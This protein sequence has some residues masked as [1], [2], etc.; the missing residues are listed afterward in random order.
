MLR[1]RQFVRR[2][3][4]LCAVL[5]LTAF[6]P[7]SFAAT[8]SWCL[9]GGEESHVTSAV[10]PCDTPQVDAA[11]GHAHCHGVVLHT[12]HLSAA[13]DLAAAPASALPLTLADVFWYPVFTLVA[14]LAPLQPPATAGWRPGSALHELRPRLAGAV[15]GESIRLLI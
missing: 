7:Q 11:A 8:L 15:A 1:F 6:V 4:G 3:P 13:S 2:W 10:Q 9:H 14:Q 5:L 12:A